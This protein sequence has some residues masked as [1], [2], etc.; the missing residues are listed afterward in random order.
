MR[1]GLIKCLTAIFIAF[2]IS[3]TGSTWLLELITRQIEKLVFLFPA[4]ALFARL[5]IALFC[6]LFLASPVI[7]F[8]IW[9]FISTGLLEKERVPVLTYTFF[10]F[11]AF[12]AGC[13][14]AYFVILPLSLKFLIGFGSSKIQPL[15]SISRYISFAGILLLIFGILFEVPIIFLFLA[16]LGIVNAQTL[17]HM[18]PSAILFI[19]I[20]G[21]ILTPPDVITQSLLVV[22]LILLYE[23]SILLLRLFIKK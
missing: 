12:F 13:I 8:Q 10:T 17:S 5:K 7:L 18:R 4:E 6:S 16:K 14:F 1:L 19:F 3:Y 23:L 9:K 15:F 2:I 20:I 21:A 22:P 11:F